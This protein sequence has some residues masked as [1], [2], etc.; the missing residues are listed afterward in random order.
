MYDK[1]SDNQKLGIAKNA[2][3]FGLTPEEYCMMR[4]EQDGD[5]GYRALALGQM[6]GLFT[7]IAAEPS[8]V[9]TIESMVDAQVEVL[10]VTREQAKMEA[11][12]EGSGL[13]EILRNAG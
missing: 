12:V 3:E 9:M 4:L 7:K 8:L 11:E 5:R 10:M 1:L 13:A 2:Q 6:Q